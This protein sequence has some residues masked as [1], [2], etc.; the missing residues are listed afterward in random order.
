MFEIK[1]ANKLIEKLKKGIYSTGVASK[2]Q[3]TQFGLWRSW[4][5]KF[6][7]P[8]VYWRTYGLLQLRPGNVRQSGSLPLL[9]A[10]QRVCGSKSLAGRILRVFFRGGNHL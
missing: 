1:I 4:D 2:W 10:T 8:Q 7:S 5:E 6:D 9:W 3:G